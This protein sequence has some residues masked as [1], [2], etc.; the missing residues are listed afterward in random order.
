M[1]DFNVMLTLHPGAIH[2]LLRIFDAYGDQL[3]PKAW[4]MCLQNVMFRLLSSIEA[5][6]EAT[7]GAESTVSEKDRAGWNETTVVVLSGISNLLAEYLDKLSAH[8]TF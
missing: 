1:L 6:L 4:S 8:H 7:S 3:S 5:Q 2:T